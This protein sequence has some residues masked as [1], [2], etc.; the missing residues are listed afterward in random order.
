MVLEG[1]V[2][3]DYI[4]GPGDFLNVE[5]HSQRGNYHHTFRVSRKCQPAFNIVLGVGLVNK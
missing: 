3:N 1:P 2:D 4:R 5:S